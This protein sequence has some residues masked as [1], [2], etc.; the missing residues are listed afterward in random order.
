M[1]ASETMAKAT[2]LSVILPL[3]G[4]AFLQ[5]DLRYLG[6]S[7]FAAAIVTVGV[8]LLAY[9]ERPHRPGPIQSVDLRS[10]QRNEAA[11]RHTR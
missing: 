5:A 9:L 8:A 10:R 3:A 7:F 4:G 2:V 11:S 1:T 6:W